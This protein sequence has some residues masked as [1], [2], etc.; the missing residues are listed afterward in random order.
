MTGAEPT[1]DG[2]R[3]LVELPAIRSIGFA[4]R[5]RSVLEWLGRHFVAVCMIPVG[6]ALGTFGIFEHLLRGRPGTNR[7]EAPPS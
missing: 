4:S 2:E 5:T 1:V 7:T 3:V 6:V